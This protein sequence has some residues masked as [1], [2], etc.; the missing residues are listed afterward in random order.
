MKNYALVFLSLVAVLAAVPSA[1]ADPYTA[2]IIFHSTPNPDGNQ[3]SIAGS[4]F[5]NT[6]QVPPAAVDVNF[7]LVNVESNLE[8]GSLI[9]G[10]PTAIETC[11]NTGTSPS[12]P[13]ISA[14]SNGPDC[15]WTLAGISFI[16]ELPIWTDLSDDGYPEGSWFWSYIWV[17]LYPNGFG[18]AVNG[19]KN[20]F[21]IELQPGGDS[22]WLETTGTLTLFGDIDGVT[23]SPE[24]SSFWLLGTGLLGVVFILLRKAKRP[25]TVLSKPIG[26]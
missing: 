9:E 3:I 5:G 7:A 8:F 17:D 16:F 15:N 22:F 14:D 26:F 10:T 19:Q 18:T 20:G 24:P 25:Q 21:T 13:T 2:G 23:Y 6:E 12:G 4:I 1:M 11:F